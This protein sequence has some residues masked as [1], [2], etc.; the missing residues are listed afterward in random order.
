MSI[1]TL[2]LYATF[3]RSLFFFFFYAPLR[4]P[5]FF[6]KEALSEFVRKEASSGFF[7]GYSRFP[8]LPPQKPTWNL[9]SN[10]NWKQW[11]KRR[12]TLWIST[13]IPIYLFYFIFIYY[14]LHAIV[15][16][17]YKFVI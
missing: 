2:V 10:S 15:K 4:N 16:D 3:T 9:N 13:E 1:F 8:Q 6:R 7:T 17:T 5:E 14:I 12:T 11:T